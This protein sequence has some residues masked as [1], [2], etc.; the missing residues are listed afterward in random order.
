[1]GERDG[2][3]LLRILVEKLHMEYEPF[4]VG[5][6]SPAI[7]GD[8]YKEL[9]SSWPDH[10]LFKSLPELGSKFAL[11]GMDNANHWSKLIKSDPWKSFHEYV[12]SDSF[13][14]IVFKWLKK[15]SVDIFVSEK[16]STRWEFSV[17]PGHGGHI[18]AH[19]DSPH[20]IVTLVLS[21]SDDWPVDVGGTEIFKVKRPADSFNFMNRQMPWKK[22]EFVRRMPFGSN[23][24][25]L[26]VKTHDSLHGVRPLNNPGKMRK[27][28]V[29][30]LMIDRLRVK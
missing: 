3:V 6:F 9:E 22:I 12:S 15:N 23:L 19:T 25:T 16:I 2:D 1:M 21:F 4:P 8:I 14:G 17:L 30:N 28:I 24:C 29:I 20:K 10:S 26:F 27:T 18:K 7:P 11:S 5:F 13:I